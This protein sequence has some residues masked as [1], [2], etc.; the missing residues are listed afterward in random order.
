MSKYEEFFEEMAESLDLNETEEARIVK[1]YNA[2]GQFL[3]GSDGLREYDLKVFCQGSMRLGTVVKPLSRDDYDIDLVCELQHGEKLEPKQVKKLVGYA[4]QSGE[5]KPLL[6]EEHGRCWTLSYPASPPYHLDILPG[7]GIAGG[8]VHAT[9]LERTGQYRWLNTNPKGFAE[10]FLSLSP[11]KVVLEDKRE[12]ERVPSFRKKSP[13]Q[14]AVQIIKR[15]RD[16]FFEANPDMG[17]ASVII[18]TLCGLS[19]DGETTIEEILKNGPI[20]WL[21]FIKIKGGK[22]SIKVPSL[23]DDDYADKWNG[24]DKGAADRFFKWHKKLILDLDALFRQTFYGDFLRASYRLFKES[25]VAKVSLAKPRMM[26]SLKE[27]FSRESRLPVKLDDYHPL[28]PHALRI[29]DQYEYIPKKDI[30]ITLS[31]RVYGSETDAYSCMNEIVSLRFDQQSPFLP[32]DRW[33]RFAAQVRNKGNANAKV[34][35]QITNTGREAASAGEGERRGDLYPPSEQY[36]RTRI[37]H[38]AYVGTHFVQAFVIETVNKRSF[39]VAKSNILTINV[40][41]SI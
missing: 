15:H 37:E 17:P 31:A 32:K 38:T 30:S 7:V 14:R 28:F 35:F 13:L 8:R 2:V 26:D 27:S 21:E 12:V 4:L 19:Y 33:I 22:Y 18:T 5:Y 11:K 23:P 39:C 24:E 9:I 36:T 10:W 3:A 40:G 16:V 1:S 34:V 20:R 29:F 41:E 25:A 6:E